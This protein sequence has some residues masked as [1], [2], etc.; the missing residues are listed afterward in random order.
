[1]RREMFHTQEKR[2]ERLTQ[3][4]RCTR[5]DAWLGYGYYFWGDLYDA[6]IWGRQSRYCVLR[7]GLS[8]LS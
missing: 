3:P 4:I 2:V 6:I 7:R 8:V 1:M 5:P